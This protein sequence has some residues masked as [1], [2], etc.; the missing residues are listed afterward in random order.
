ML[1]RSFK[2]MDIAG[3]PV[4]VHWT[5]G[6]FFL[7]IIYIGTNAGLSNPGLLRLAFFSLA[8]FV[9]VI[10]HELGH[11]LTAR[12]YGVK[13]KDI[14]ISP[15]GGVAR[16]LNIPSKP[17]Q[18]LVIAIA[19]PL[20]NLVL[21]VLLALGLLLFRDHGL[22]PIGEP[23]RVF[24]YPGNFFPTL[25]ILNTALIVFNMVPAFPM[26]GGRVLRAFLSMR[27]GRLKA[28]RWAAWIGQ[29]FS[30]AFIFLGFYWS[31]YILVFIGVFVIFSAATEYQMVRAEARLRD[32]EVHQVMRSIFTPIHLSDSMDYVVRLSQ[33]GNEHDFIVIDGWGQVVGV[34]HHEFVMEAKKEDDGEA[35]VSAYMSQHFHALTPGDNMH[36]VLLVFQKNG[37]SIVPVI[38]EG[39]LVGVLDRSDIQAFVGGRR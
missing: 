4:K 12:K 1:G 29:V 6:F 13:T 7:W 23:D 21:A 34:L 33:S 14:I 37:Y 17:S 22:L 8:L 30:V 16:L 24:D 38:A 32:H 18:E 20:V 3:I 36:E 9:C 2:M 35:N 31:D 15:I 28:T 5:F 25:L 27:W 19:G 39:R 11:A 26:D 10:L